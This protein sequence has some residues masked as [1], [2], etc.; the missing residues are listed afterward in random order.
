MNKN[1][2]VSNTCDR[3][4]R[5]NTISPCNAR[6]YSDSFV[7][8]FFLALDKFCPRGMTLERGDKPTA[9]RNCC[10]VGQLEH[11]KRFTPSLLQAHNLTAPC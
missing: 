10:G 2:D 8:I 3:P 5:C 1:T 7:V 11:G 9:K 6:K 4:E